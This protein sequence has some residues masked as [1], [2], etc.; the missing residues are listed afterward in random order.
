MPLCMISRGLV[1]HVHQHVADKEAMSL[2][3][4]CMCC[5]AADGA[6]DVDA[7]GLLKA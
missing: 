5:A 6:P 3:L 7:A 4:A 1:H 2:S